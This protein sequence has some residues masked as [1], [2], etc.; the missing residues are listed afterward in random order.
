MGLAPPVT[1]QYLDHPSKQPGA[2]DNCPNCLL[3]ESM[4]DTVTET[5]Q[6][7]Y[8]IKW[9]VSTLAAIKQQTCVHEESRDEVECTQLHPECLVAVTYVVCYP[10]RY[11][12]YIIY[13]LYCTWQI[14]SFVRQKV[15]LTE[16]YCLFLLLRIF[17]VLCPCVAG[18]KKR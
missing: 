14:L 4:P 8:T 3:S 13:N 5:L 18:M 6:Y 2:K 15:S 10:P 7:P 17:P 16:R 9:H 12:H 11:I 1:S